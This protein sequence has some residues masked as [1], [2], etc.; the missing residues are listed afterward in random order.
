MDLLSVAL[1][2]ERLNG[3]IMHQI[4]G[5][6]GEVPDNLHIDA[7][8][9]PPVDDACRAQ[10]DCHAAQRNVV[11]PGNPDEDAD[12]GSDDDDDDNP[13]NNNPGSKGSVGVG[14]RNGGD[15]VGGNDGGD[16]GND[17]NPAG[18]HG[19]GIPN[20]VAGA[21]GGGGTAVAE[22]EPDGYYMRGDL[23]LPAG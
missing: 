18:N 8:D 10:A 15:G 11:V 6:E 4:H 22:D 7:V 14:D 5:G 1:N 3:N 20:A 17:G 12:P 19:G 23:Q 2:N 9:H 16:D 13:R 21:G